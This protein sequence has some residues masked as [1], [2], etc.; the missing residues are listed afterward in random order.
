VNTLLDLI[1]N[2]NYIE[3]R[4]DGSANEKDLSHLVPRE[5]WTY[6]GP[7][8]EKMRS[9][10]LRFAL[11]G[12]FALSAYSNRVRATK[13]LDLFVRPEDRQRFIEALTDSGFTDYHE[14]CPY[15]RSWIYRGYRDRAIVD[16]IWEMANHRAAV[17]ERWLCGDRCVRLYGTRLR[18][19]PLEELIWAKLYVMQHDRCDW[20]DL[21]NLLDSAVDS[22]DWRR[23]LLRVGDDTDLLGSLL[24]SFRWLS[25]ERARAVPGNVLELLGICPEPALPT[26][27]SSADRARLLDS[28]DWLGPN[29]RKQ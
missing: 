15:D 8:L 7:A 11:G 5:D 21:L 2:D 23:L 14:T 19:I 22:I 29:G 16:I 26:A 28:R 20:P 6:V 18:V 13:D 3:M 1:V 9:R 12:G 25:P 10:G 17:D 27:G 24:G 4:V